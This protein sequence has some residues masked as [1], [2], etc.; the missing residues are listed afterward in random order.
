MFPIGR[1][2]SSLPV[3]ICLGSSYP[4]VYPYL[5]T[6]NSHTIW[7]LSRY[8]KLVA[9]LLQLLQGE[10]HSD[11][12]SAWR[13]K[14]LWCDWSIGE[15]HR[16]PTC[17][18]RKRGLSRRHWMRVGMG[19]VISVWDHFWWELLSLSRPLA[20]IYGSILLLVYLED[21]LVSW[22]VGSLEGWS[23]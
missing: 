12:Y 16:L 23:G 5:A 19:M 3:A 17:I 21:C 2:S 4:W 18:H 11:S 1:P 22:L 6:R 8:Q 15:G 20:S 14:T 13:S 9:F 7:S 10:I